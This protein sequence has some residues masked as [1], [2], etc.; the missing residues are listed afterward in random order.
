MPFI[1][2]KTN[3]S[4][5]EEKKTE[6]KSEFGKAI[7]LIPGKSENWLMV[8]IEDGRCMYFR[9][10]SREAIVFVEVKLFGSATHEVYDKLT[11]RITDI[12]R[13]TAEAEEIYIKY[14]E[15]E[16]WGYNGGNF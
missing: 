15:V 13:E 3:R 10:S 1:S 14:E 12:L 11:E 16:T 4:I 6:L 9:G 2:V 8:D 7:S 5:S